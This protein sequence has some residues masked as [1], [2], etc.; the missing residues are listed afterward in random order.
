MLPVIVKQISEKC[1]GYNH[2][3]SLAYYENEY[4]L[5]DG[6]TKVTYTVGLSGLE[7]Y[8]TLSMSN[9]TIVPKQTENK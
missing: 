1:I 8:P 2:D 6:S 7:P 9:V 5:S 3:C 4:L